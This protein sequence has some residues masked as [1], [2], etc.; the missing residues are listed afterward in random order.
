MHLILVIS[1]KMYNQPTSN[2]TS[3]AM[4]APVSTQASSPSFSAD[5]P[6]VDHPHAGFCQANVQTLR[7][8]GDEYV[9]AIR[10]QVRH[11][12][13][14]NVEVMQSNGQER[15]DKSNPPLLVVGHDVYSS[16][17]ELVSSVALRCTGDFQV[18]MAGDR[19]FSHIINDGKRGDPHIRYISV[20][21]DGHYVAR[22]CFGPDGPDGMWRA[23]APNEA[24]IDICIL[25]TTVP[26]TSRWSQLL[27]GAKNACPLPRWA[28]I[29]GSAA[30]VT[31]VLAAACA[32]ARA[33]RMR[34]GL[35]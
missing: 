9:H 5:E 24:P 17:V 4:S 13:G 11:P 3:T 7:S 10:D 6:R 31:G 18:A 26:P 32:V 15:F 33:S 16:Q 1:N 14:Y 25:Y 35:Y 28:R 8:R 34:R 12:E 21:R 19:A 27:I 29:L 30:V 2:K 20:F 22:F 23:T